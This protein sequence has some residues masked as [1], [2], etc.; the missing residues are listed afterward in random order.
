MERGLSDEEIA[1]YDALAENKS[2]G[3]SC[4]SRRCG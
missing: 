3:K 1:F 4:A 2:G